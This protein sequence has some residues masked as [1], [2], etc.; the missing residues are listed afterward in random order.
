MKYGNSVIGS[1]GIA[2][3]GFQYQLPRGTGRFCP[4]NISAMPLKNA[5]SRCQPFSSCNATPLEPNIIQA[6]A[7][8]FTSP[9]LPSKQTNNTPKT[10]AQKEMP[11]NFSGESLRISLLMF[12]VTLNVAMA[13]KEYQSGKMML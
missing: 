4:L 6:S 1:P 10:P 11:N 12:Q 5:P 9:K 2:R 3:L 8:T 13:N 7:I